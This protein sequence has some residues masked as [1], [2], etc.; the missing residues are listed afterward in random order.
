MEMDFDQLFLEVV[1]MF[2]NQ[3]IRK[4][5]AG[6]QAD[7]LAWAPAYTTPGLDGF[8]ISPGIMQVIQAGKLHVSN[9]LYNPDMVFINPTDAIKATTMQNVK[10]DKTFIPASEVFAGLR[11]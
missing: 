5:N 1:L 11:V 9:K 10:G 3:V 8:F 4:W 2:E 6:V 7:I